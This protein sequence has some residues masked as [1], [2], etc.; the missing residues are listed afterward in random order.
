VE[1]GS[2]SYPFRFE[3]DSKDRDAKIVD[4]PANFVVGKKDSV[5]LSL[6]NSRNGAI[7]DIII[8]PSGNGI[9]VSPLQK[10]I[11]AL[12]AGSS[13][14]ASFQ[15]TPSQASDLIFHTSPLFFTRDIPN[16]TGLQIYMHITDLER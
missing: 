11:G 13:Q 16:G 12:A 4:R 3:I 15:V 8:T 6:V 10:F 9:M 1:A 2:I 7:T 14:I 5:N